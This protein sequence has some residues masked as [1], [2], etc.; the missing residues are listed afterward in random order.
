MQGRRST[1]AGDGVRNFQ[2]T[3]EII[4]KGFYLWTRNVVARKKH[5][6]DHLIFLLSHLWLRYPY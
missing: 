6:P 5:L 4:F 2:V 1:I 3:T